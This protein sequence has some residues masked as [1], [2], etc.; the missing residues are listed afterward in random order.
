MIHKIKLSVTYYHQCHLYKCPNT[1][2]VVTWLLT[3]FFLN[4]DGFGMTQMIDVILCY[5]SYAASAWSS[6]HFRSQ[7]YSVKRKYLVHIFYLGYNITDK[8]QIFTML[9]SINGTVPRF[10][11]KY[12]TI[13]LYNV[14]AVN[15]DHWHPSNLLV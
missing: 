7:Y 2:L 13:S 4:S 8:N 14:Y 15:Y 3:V 11:N 5:F 1:V 10:R 9:K 6:L 12:K